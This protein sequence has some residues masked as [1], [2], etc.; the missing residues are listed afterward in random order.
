MKREKGKANIEMEKCDKLDSTS[1]RSLSLPLSC[2]LLSPLWHPGHSHSSVE[3][4]V[5]QDFFTKCLS[6]LSLYVI[7]S[8]SFSL[9]KSP[10]IS[11]SR[12][13]SCNERTRLVFA[14]IPVPDGRGGEMVERELNLMRNF[15]SP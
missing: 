4:K 2:Y 5:P 6:S 12:K 13:F 10:P 11:Y 14:K 9:H 1:T 7:V 3:M 8:L 15:V